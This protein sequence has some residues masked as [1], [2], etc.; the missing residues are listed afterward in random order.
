MREFVGDAEPVEDRVHLKTPQ[1]A[2][3]DEALSLNIRVESPM[4]EDDHVR[5]IH[6]FASRESESRVVSFTLSPMIGRAEI[7]TRIRLSVSQDLFALVIMNDG[8]RFIGRRS[9]KV[10]RSA[11]GDAI[12]HD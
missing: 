7:A 10:S 9:V 11:Y 1:I 2:Q 4:T 5:H 8:R 6:V 12:G 3:P